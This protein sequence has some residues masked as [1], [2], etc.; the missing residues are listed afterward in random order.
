M[1]DTD[2]DADLDADTDSDSLNRKERV[3]ISES[4]KEM[5]AISLSAIWVQTCVGMLCWELQGSQIGLGHNNII[6]LKFHCVRPRIIF[7][8]TRAF[9]FSDKP[10]LSILTIIV[11]LVSTWSKL[12]LLL[13]QLM[14]KTLV[15]CRLHQN[16]S[17]I[18][19]PLQK[20]KSLIQ[21]QG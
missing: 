19:Y 7:P 6:M 13:W 21:L 11:C 10:C 16:Y 17:I 5:V 14:N 18:S 1:A 4:D 8:F 3:V 15:N 2:T 9:Q 12:A 20:M